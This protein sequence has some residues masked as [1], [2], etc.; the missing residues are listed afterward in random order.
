MIVVT[1]VTEHG[2]MPYPPGK[3]VVDSALKSRLSQILE[4]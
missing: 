1:L 4:I 3:M 2:Q